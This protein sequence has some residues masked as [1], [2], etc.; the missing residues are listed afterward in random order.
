MFAEPTI[1]RPFGAWNHRVLTGY[2]FAR[3]L[4]RKAAQ[5]PSLD[6]QE[7]DTPCFL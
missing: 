5:P 4:L 7:A 2:L 1:G 3:Y 6:R